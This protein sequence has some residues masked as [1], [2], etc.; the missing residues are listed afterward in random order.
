MLY[1]SCAMTVQSA[2]PIHSLN[3]AYALTLDEDAGRASDD[4][5][6]YLI[7]PYVDGRGYAWEV[8]WPANGPVVW[9]TRYELDTTTLRLWVRDWSDAGSGTSNGACVSG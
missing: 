3:Y 7:T 6:A 8:Q 9:A 4:F 5:G 1:L 2:D